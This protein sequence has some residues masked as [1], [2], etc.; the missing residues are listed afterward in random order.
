MQDVHALC[1]PSVARCTY[2][3]LILVPTS[4]PLTA[5]AGGAVEV[6]PEPRPERQPHGALVPAVPGRAGH[7]E[8]RRGGTRRPVRRRLHGRRR[9]R[10]TPAGK[11]LFVLSP[12]PGP[13]HMTCLS[14]KSRTFCSPIASPPPSG[15]LGA[16]LVIAII[17]AKP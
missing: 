2:E 7:H 3:R 6:V 16:Q 15:T 12:V 9:C 13:R 11:P 17:V 14:P 8:R 1:L 10:C 4:H 5:D